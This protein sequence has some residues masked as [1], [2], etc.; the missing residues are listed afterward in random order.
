MGSYEP[1]HPNPYIGIGDNV[2]MRLLWQ[3]MFGNA[4]VGNQMT[5]SMPLLYTDTIIGLSQWPSASCM[6]LFRKDSKR[7]SS[8]L[9]LNFTFDCSR[10]ED[11]EAGRSN[12]LA[13]LSV[14]MNLLYQLQTDDI[15]ITI[16][17]TIE[18][19]E[20]EKEGF[21]KSVDVNSLINGFI[22][23]V[24]DYLSGKSPIPPAT[25]TLTE[26]V[27]QELVASYCNVIPL[28]VRLAMKRDR[29]ISPD[30]ANS[31]GV[32]SVSTVIQPS[33]SLDG[34]MLG[35]TIFA[36]EFEE[37]FANGDIQVKIATSSETL[38]E[39]KDIWMVQIRRNRQERN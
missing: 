3:D 29:N 17:S 28:C 9:V 39:G 11:G 34:G 10:Y 19:T 27:E 22:T 36:Q 12:A 1:A 5:V 31:P 8:C 35:F 16:L 4:M 37:A 33:H 32:A 2:E 14:Y 23:P 7:Q 25:F 30:F 6:Y 26:T 13:D 38:G 20:E 24:I 18:G 15:S 21:K